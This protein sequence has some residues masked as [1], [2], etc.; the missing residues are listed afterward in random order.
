MRLAD[1]QLDEALS[2]LGLYV[3]EKQ[4]MVRPGTPPAVSL[5]WTGVLGRVAFSDRVLN[6]DAVAVADE[7]DGIAAALSDDTFEERRRR[8]LGDD[9]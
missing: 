4:I 2:D 8:L 1:E 3:T 7:F 9:D 6:P 5:V